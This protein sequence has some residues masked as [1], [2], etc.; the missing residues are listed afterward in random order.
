M[1]RHTRLIASVPGLVVAL[2]VAG[3]GLSVGIAREPDGAASTADAALDGASAPDVVIAADHVAPADVVQDSCAP[4]DVR[5]P[6]C[7]STCEHAP[8]YWNGESCVAAPSCTCTGADCGRTYPR[9]ELCVA[10]HTSCAAP[11]C[12]ATGGRWMAVHAYCGH[13]ACGHPT[14]QNCLVGGPACDCGVGRRFDNALGCVAD[15]SC[16]RGDL[17]VATGGVVNAGAGCNI[18]GRPSAVC[19]P[20]TE[21]C[22]CGP[23][24]NYDVARGCVPDASCGPAHEELCRR[25]G[26]TYVFGGCMDAVCGRPSLIFCGSAACN[27]GPDQIFEPGRG[28]VVSA[29]CNDRGVGDTCDP[30]NGLRCTRGAVC[31]AGRCAQPCCGAACNA[32]TGCPT[33]S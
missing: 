13:F 2:L 25:S 11:L 32:E 16:T 6:V 12:N 31:C 30:G 22:D 23:A 8:Y 21:G 15:P 27:C 5:F 3:C 1:Y 17:C 28:C 18:C 7:G 10:A 33:G 9:P 19:D 20:G 14:P 29:T 26:G 4:M 24:M